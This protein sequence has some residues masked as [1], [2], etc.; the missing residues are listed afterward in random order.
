MSAMSLSSDTISIRLA[1]PDDASALA[2]LAVLDSSVVPADPV[3]LAEREDQL[4]AALGLHDGSVVADPFVP[5]AELVALLRTRAE[6]LQP[7]LGLAARLRVTALARR[8][9]RAYA[10]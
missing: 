10:A 8:R 5:T 6:R 7:K 4:Q 1:T 9:R 3:L 2:R